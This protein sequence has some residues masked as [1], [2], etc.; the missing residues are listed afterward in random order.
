MKLSFEVLP[1]FLPLWEDNKRYFLLMGG[2]GAGRSTAASQFVVSKLPAQDYF[3]CAI[4]RAVHS[5][6]RHSIW[7]EINDRIEEQ[8]ARNAF[9]ITE[10]DM[11]VAYGKNSV[12][13]HGFRASSGTLTAKLKS[14]ANYN[15]VVIEEAEEIGEEEFRTLDD[16][17]R[18]VRGD[19][20]I[21]LCLNTPPKN[22]WIIKKWFDLENSE[23]QGF[24]I[25]HLKESATDTRFI[26]GNFNINIDNLDLATINR[27][28]KYKET[29]PNYY[30]QMIEGLVP[31]VVRGKIY[32]GWEMIDVVPQEARLLRYGLDFGWYPDPAC[33]VA[34]YYLNGGYII[35]EIAYDTEITNEV[36]AGLVEDKDVPVI[37]D[38][39]EPKSINEISK[40]GV[41]IRGCEKGKDSVN[42]G[43]QKVSEKKI[44]VTKRSTNVWRDYEMYAWDEDKDGN[45]KGTPVHEWS[46]A[47]D[48]IR[49]AL[50]DIT[51][52]NTKA[53]TRKPSW[54]T[55]PVDVEVKAKTRKPNLVKH[56]HR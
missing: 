23:A 40:Y 25:P 29:N 11:S 42:Y 32:H 21:I 3:R 22:H 30:W 54:A 56:Y 24:Y 5:D 17:L 27:Y 33:L 38:S 26:T 28:K 6:V 18:T 34:V 44:A 52:K 1:N 20:K 15:T 41:K 43:I 37:A 50:V 7:R 12:H 16:S 8:N 51:G 36:L 47:P 46:H 35:D 39:A 19:I 9:H 55:K 31:E 2:R 4:M 13:A 49:Y 53:H 48:A 45:P 14:L 10:N